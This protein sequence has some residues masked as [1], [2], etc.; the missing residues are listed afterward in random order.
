MEERG[1][2]SVR[3]QQNER[4]KRKKGDGFDF[5]NTVLE[6]RVTSDDLPRFLV[7]FYFSS[8]PIISMGERAHLLVHTDKG[9]RTHFSA[10][11]I[12]YC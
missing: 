4:G 2:K 9:A 5:K 1:D 3:L 6:P 11:H 10:L 12:T 8:H 7:S